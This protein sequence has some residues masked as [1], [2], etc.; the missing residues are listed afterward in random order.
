MRPIIVAVDFSE[1][2]LNALEHAISISRKGGIDLR[3]IWVKK[4]DSTTPLYVEG[5]GDVIATAEKEFKN[6][7]D[8]YQPTL[9]ESQLDYKIREGKVHRE[10]LQ[11]AKETNAFLIVTGAYGTSGF[12]EKWIGSNANR[13]VSGASCPV[14]T[15]QGEISISR[16]LSRI[17]MP[18]DSTME[19]RMKVPFTALIA[20]MFDAE[21][22]V[23]ELYS[24]KVDNVRK[25]V[26]GYAKMAVKYLIENKVKHVV[27][28]IEV[29]N[30][31]DDIIAYAKS[32]DANLISI[33]TEMEKSAKNWW[34]GSYAE[35]LTNNSPF[36]VLVMHPK[37][38]IMSIA[39][40]G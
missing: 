7:I 39:S 16:D 20:K 36:P 4:P 19:T 30:L 23:L 14:I 25:M 33:M 15:I 10:I 40:G 27:D 38:G 6:L 24:T 5:K 11:E 2:S 34:L 1:C 9:P 13:I 8:K 32:V 28:A 3:M 22:H 21:I 17:V 12:E 18:I 37:E 29:N 35:Q 31:A 26:D